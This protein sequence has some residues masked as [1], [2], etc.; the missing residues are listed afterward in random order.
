MAYKAIYLWSN[1]FVKNELTSS[2]ISEHCFNFIFHIFQFQSCW[3]IGRNKNDRTGFVYMVCLSVI[4]FQSLMLFGLSH[5]FVTM[6]N[7]QLSHRNKMCIQQLCWIT[8][9]NHKLNSDVTA[10][11]SKNNLFNLNILPFF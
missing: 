7:V 6:M 10:K 3:N 11:A 2:D 1:S 9:F 8:T 4:G 5:F